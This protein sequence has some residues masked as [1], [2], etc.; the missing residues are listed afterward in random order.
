MC[1]VTLLVNGAH[2]PCHGLGLATQGV[3]VGYQHVDADAVGVQ[4][5][6]EILDGEVDFGLRSR[7]TS[8]SKI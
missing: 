2:H 4:A 8:I 7:T 1:E 3:V 5:V 6:E